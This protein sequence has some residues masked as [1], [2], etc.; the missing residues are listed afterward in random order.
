MSTTAH[1]QP[2]SE[3]AQ[4]VGAPPTGRAGQATL[5]REFGEFLMELSIALHKHTIY[6]GDHP[7]LKPTVSRLAGRL[8]MMLE[9]RGSVS[10]GIAPQQ[11]VIEGVATDPKHPVLQ[12]LAQRLHGHHLGAI[13]FR[14]GVTRD[15]VASVLRTISVEADR[16]RAIGLLPS[17]QLP[18]WE[19]VKLHPVNYDGLHIDDDPGGSTAFDRRPYADKLWIGLASVALSTN[20]DDEHALSMDPVFVARSIDEQS[21]GEGYDQAIVGYLHQSARELKF[22]DADSAMLRRRISRLLAAVSPE[23]LH[24]LMRMDG[25]PERRCEF[26]ADATHGVAVDALLKIVHAASDASTQSIS[27]SLWRM[28]SKLAAHAE[29]GTGDA[30]MEADGALRDQVRDLFTGWELKDPNPAAYGTVLD[31]LAAATAGGVSIEQPAQ[32]RDAAMEVEPVRIVQM[33]LEAEL[34]GLGVWDAVEV[35]VEQRALATLIGLVESVPAANVTAKAIW[36]RIASADAFGRMLHEGTVESQPVTWIVATLGLEAAR[37]MFNKLVESQSR[38]ERRV[39]MDQ[40]VRL[41]PAIGTFAIERLDDERWFVKRNMLA[42]LSRLSGWP[43]GFSPAEHSSHSDARVRREAVKLRLKMPGERARALCQALE[44]EDTR[45]VSMALKDAQRTCPQEAADLIASGLTENR[46]PETLRVLAIHTLASTRSP[47]ALSMLLNMTLVPGTWWR[48]HRLA[49]KSPELIAALTGLAAHWPSDPEV[50][51]ALHLAA[52]S[53]DSDIK[54]VVASEKA[55]V[56]PARA[57]ALSQN[58]TGSSEMESET[59]LS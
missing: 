26:V 40:L 3:D 21:K 28:L 56:P 37:P 57:S 47:L 36:A 54:A 18:S 55:T 13:T 1:E 27:Q 59:L 35:L 34:T 32:V 42:L 9:D 45:I 20:M 19:H 33:A 43:D 24:R 46:F 39:L 51:A 49:R 16:D 58:T 15:E 48:R 30:R 12:R 7:L 25:D 10:L 29:C 22:G 2:V 50:Q 17:E 14:K 41:G 6:P 52:S 53:D 11:L 38:A 44:D 8:S 31:D 23:T 4:P 5:S